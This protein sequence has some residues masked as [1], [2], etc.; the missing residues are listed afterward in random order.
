[1]AQVAEHVTSID[2]HRGDAGTGPADTWRPFLANL[3]RFDV[4]MRVAPLRCDIGELDVERFRHAYDM[5]FVDAAHDVASVA[6]DT[7]MALGAVRPGGVIAWHDVDYAS[8]QETLEF[9]NLAP[10]Q[11]VDNLAWMIV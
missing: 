6:R 5:V 7:E 1:M 10:D 4:W 2:H 11:R 3:R 8:V 9:Y